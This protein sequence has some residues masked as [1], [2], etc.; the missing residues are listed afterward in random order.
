M[1]KIR[2]FV[3]AA[4]VG[5]QELSHLLYCPVKLL[6][7]VYIFWWAWS[8][9]CIFIALLVKWETRHCPTRSFPGLCLAGTR[10][11]SNSQ[12]ERA[13]SSY[14]KATCGHDWVRWRLKYFSRQ[15]ALAQTPSSLGTSPACGFSF[16]KSPTEKKC[17]PDQE[18]L[19]INTL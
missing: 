7:S 19:A 9:G 1:P 14:W 3:T 11:T 2:Q 15:P 8:E 4:Q 18:G 17:E 16:L 10:L 6:A 5:L 12:K 13:T